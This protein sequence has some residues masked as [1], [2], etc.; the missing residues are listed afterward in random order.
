M[1]AEL[2]YA[3]LAHHQ[4][5]GRPENDGYLHTGISK[6][7]ITSTTLVRST[8][9]R[10]RLLWRKGADE[11]PD[12]FYYKLLNGGGSFYIERE[13]GPQ[14]RSRDGRQNRIRRA[15]YGDFRHHG[16][17]RHDLPLQLGRCGYSIGNPVGY[18]IEN[19]MEMY[20]DRERR[21]RQQHNVLVSSVP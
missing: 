6:P 3:G 18:K 9:D 1:V 21:R 12:R 20:G 17:G 14:D 19:G 4:R 8:T 16:Y 11:D 15:G 7:D 2:R 5:R 13:L 10:M